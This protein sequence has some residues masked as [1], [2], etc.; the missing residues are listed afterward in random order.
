SKAPAGYGF[1]PQEH[2]EAIYELIRQL[3]LKDLIVVVQDWGGP[4]GL[5]Y[6]VRHRSNLRGIVVMNTWAWPARILP[7]RLF[8][9]V[10]GGWPFGYWLQTRRNF[11]AKVIVPSGIFHTDK[12]TDQLRK[13]YT[14]PFQTPKSRIPTWMFPRQI[15]KARAWLSDTESK[16]SNLSDLPAR[17]LWGTKDSAGFPLG[18][19]NKWQSYLPL[20]ETE[21]LDDAS[22]YLQEDRPDRVAAAIRGL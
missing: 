1:T 20:N 13:A 14:D 6:A 10:M 2:S 12:V 22:H 15:R 18:Q 17:I 21:I 11:F 16:L 7:M 19:M 4:I 3:D 5:H 8:S 9:L